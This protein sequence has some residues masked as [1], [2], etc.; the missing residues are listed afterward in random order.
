V[1]AGLKPTSLR[2][3]RVL[4]DNENGNG[5]KIRILQGAPSITRKGKVS[6]SIRKVTMGVREQ[7]FIG[8][9]EIGVRKQEKGGYSL[10]EP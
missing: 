9:P 4:S 5:L 1:K 8:N 7:N 10:W 3:Q 6:E 2:W